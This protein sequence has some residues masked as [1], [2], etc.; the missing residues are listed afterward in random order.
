MSKE[1]RLINE[2]ELKTLLNQP[3]RTAA[4]TGRETGINKSTISRYKSGILKFDNITVKNL[5][6]LSKLYINNFES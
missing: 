5:K 4:Q 6:K 3:G 2:E 1:I